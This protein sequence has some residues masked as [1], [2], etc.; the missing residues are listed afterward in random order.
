MSYDK[1]KV[2]LKNLNVL[3]QIRQTNILS[4][5]ISYYS[6]FSAGLTWTEAS[7]KND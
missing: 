7:Q 3:A 5:K 2:D 6:Y 1:I 4:S